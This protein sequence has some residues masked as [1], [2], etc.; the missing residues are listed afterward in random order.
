MGTV[1][2]DDKNEPTHFN[3]MRFPNMPPGFGP[4]QDWRQFFGE[5]GGFGGFRGRGKGHWKHVAKH[6]INMAE[7]FVNAQNSGE[8][9]KEGCGWKRGGCGKKWAEKRAIFTKM[10]ENKIVE[11]DPGS[12]VL[13]E[14]EVQNNTKWPWK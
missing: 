10:P 12:Y 14:V 7:D 5:R 13:F 9:E 6:F 11:G 1:I 2:N 4:Q 3:H 8:E